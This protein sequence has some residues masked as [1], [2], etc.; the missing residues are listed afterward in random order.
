MRSLMSTALYAHEHRRPQ[1]ALIHYLLA[2][3]PSR[4]RAAT[5]NCESR[6]FAS[7]ITSDGRPER[8]SERVAA[9]VEAMSLVLCEV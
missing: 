1:R 7:L 6:N 5:P 8:S 3:Q 4:L 2:A 9:V